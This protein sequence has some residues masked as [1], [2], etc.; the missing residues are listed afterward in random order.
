MDAAKA[1]EEKT[2][3]ALA[4]EKLALISEKEAR[5]E[6]VL[7]KNQAVARLD[8]A[9]YGQFL[10]EVAF[11]NSSIDRRD[12]VAAENAL[13]AIKSRTYN[14]EGVDVDA[15]QIIDWEWYYLNY[16]CHPEVEIIKTRGPCLVAAAAD[17]AVCRRL[18][19]SQ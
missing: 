8:D 19:R 7:A 16:L 4:S 18:R 9:V 10:S 12:P 2:K 14:V 13:T 6:A 3:L 15:S 1:S 17:G 5:E 11:A